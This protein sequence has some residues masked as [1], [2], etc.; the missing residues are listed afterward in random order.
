MW[1]YFNFS[2]FPLFILN[3]D[4]QTLYIFQVFY[5]NARKKLD[6]NNKQ[7]KQDYT[8]SRL[9]NIDISFNFYY[10]TKL[11][12]DYTLYYLL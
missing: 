1:Y 7:K 11:T 12:I 6:E 9:S 4:N 5:F 3:I 10:Y 2:N 8:F